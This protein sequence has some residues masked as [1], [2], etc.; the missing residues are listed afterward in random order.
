MQS[1]ESMHFRFDD[2]KRK[3][4]VTWNWI[5]QRNVKLDRR[6][7]TLAVKLDIENGLGISLNVNANRNRAYEAQLFER[8]ARKRPYV[9]KVNQVKEF[10]FA[11]EMFEKPSSF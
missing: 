8:L 4:T 7:S 9:N 10:K 1:D 2:C 6:Q 11:K 5:N 3:T